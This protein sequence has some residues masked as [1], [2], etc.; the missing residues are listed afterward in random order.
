VDVEAAASKLLLVECRHFLLGWKCRRLVWCAASGP[1]YSVCGVFSI[2]DS[3]R[4]LGTGVDVGAAAPKSSSHGV[5]S[6]PD[7]ADG[8]SARVVLTRV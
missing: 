8:S 4:G 2:L 6:L 3:V 5:S 7:R 1:V